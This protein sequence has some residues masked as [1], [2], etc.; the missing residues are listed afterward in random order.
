MNYRSKQSHWTALVFFLAASIAEA[1]SFDISVIGK[2]SKTISKA[3]PDAVKM[4]FE[5]PQ[6]EDAYTLTNVVRTGGGIS[7]NQYYVVSS[8]V[9]GYSQGI[10]LVGS[11]AGIE[12]SYKLATAIYSRFDE[13]HTNRDAFLVL[14][15]DASGNVAELE[16]VKWTSNSANNEVTICYLPTNQELGITFY[17]PTA[18]DLDH[19][20]VLPERKEAL[21]E[22]LASI[23]KR[24]AE[25]SKTS[26]SAPT[27][28]ELVSFISQIRTEQLGNIEPESIPAAEFIEEVTAPEPAI[29]EPAE[30]VFAKPI[31]EDVEPSQ[32][33][34]LWLVGPVIVVG[35]I[36][37]IRRKKQTKRNPESHD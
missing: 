21:E 12:D 6:D 32:N 30:V 35:G 4:P 26:L 31:E 24:M 7:I 1:A 17:D 25:G 36:L 10:S 22:H 3:Y 8:V 34:L 23:K 18:F 14:R 9:Q 33:W 13:E 37:M 2:S 28:T 11:A 27:G 19:F 29:E 5:H 20:F 15:T 16:A